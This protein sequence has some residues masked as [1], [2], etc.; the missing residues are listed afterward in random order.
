MIDDAYLEIADC[1]G[2]VN[3][4]IAGSETKADFINKM[5]LLRSELDS[6]INHLETDHAENHS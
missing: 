2:K 5:K 4:H 3:L 6:F 1:R